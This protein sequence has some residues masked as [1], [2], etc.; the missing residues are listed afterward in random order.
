MINQDNILKMYEG[1]INKKEL[2]TKNLKSYG[3][4][5]KD[6]SKLITDKILKR[7]KRGHY[8]FLGVND[9]YCY[10]KQLI[11]IKEYDKADACFLECYKLKP[12]HNGV[13]IYLFAKYI[14]SDE[15][16]KALTY[17]QK[18]Y[19]SDNIFYNVDNNFYLYLLNIITELPPKYKEIANLTNFNDIKIYSNDKRYSDVSLYN[20][21]R[22]DALEHNFSE[23]L[24]Q[25]NILINLKGRISI[26]D[27]VTKTLLSKIIEK[28]KYNRCIILDL[29][30]DKKYEEIKLN[31]ENSK[32][33]LN[34]EN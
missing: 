26:I 15:Y 20:N 1:I 33:L 29:L 14:K 21:I 30:Q 7:I 25:L 32:S 11:D 9:L 5:S 2:T 19:N 31:Y 8:C 12:N 18:F 28:E 17:F 34:D 4:N 3:F 10:G 24:D 6:L 22:K 13:C 23:A 27:I 16:E